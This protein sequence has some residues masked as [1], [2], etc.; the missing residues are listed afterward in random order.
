MSSGQKNI[1]VVKNIALM[2]WRAVAKATWQ[3]VV[4]FLICGT[5]A[6]TVFT[7]CSVSGFPGWKWKF[8]GDHCKLSFSPLSPSFASAFHN[9]PKWRACSQAKY[10]SIPFIH[11]SHLLR[12]SP[13]TFERCIYIARAEYF[14][15]DFGFYFFKA[16]LEPYSLCCKQNK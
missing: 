11:T 2:Q 8:M 14:L 12:I 16:S 15:L 1:S 10:I 3:A 13:Y 9:I 7:L 6:V 5:F 4:T